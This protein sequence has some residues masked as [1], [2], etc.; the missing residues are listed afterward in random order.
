MKSPSGPEAERPRKARAR[1]RL[2]GQGRAEGGAGPQLGAEV[3]TESGFGDARFC[4]E[5][6]RVYRD[7]G[8]GG[9]SLWYFRLQ[10]LATFT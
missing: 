10:K 2:E 6:G 3:R 4:A 7:S 9:R 1:P 5:A 8:L